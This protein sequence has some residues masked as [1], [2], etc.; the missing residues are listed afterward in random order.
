[1]LEDIETHARFSKSK[2]T[3]RLHFAVLRVVQ[4]KCLRG[5]VDLKMYN[6][7]PPHTVVVEDATLLSQT[8]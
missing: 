7:P 2:W 8:N 3:C 4:W 6:M 1:M 5:A